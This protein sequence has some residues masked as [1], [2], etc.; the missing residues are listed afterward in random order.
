MQT[1]AK[2]CKGVVSSENGKKLINVPLRLMVRQNIQFRLISLTVIS[3][4]LYI[5]GLFNI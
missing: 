5:F 1:R 2:T 3:T 4:K